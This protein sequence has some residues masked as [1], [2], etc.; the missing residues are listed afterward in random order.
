MPGLTEEYKLSVFFH[1]EQ[2]SNLRVVFVCE[3]G[4]QDL[5][6]EFEECAELI[7]REF[8]KKKII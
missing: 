3:E 5:L 8:E 4:K 2:Y 6:A 1:M 7:C